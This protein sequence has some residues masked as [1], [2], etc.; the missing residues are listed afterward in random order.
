MSEITSY[1][2]VCGTLLIGASLLISFAIT[3]IPSLPSS[4]PA[5]QAVISLLR[6]VE[7]PDDAVIYELGS[8]W[9]S[10]AIELARA[11]PHAQV[12]GIEIS[13]FPYLVSRLRALRHANARFEWGNF[14]RCDL[15]DAD[16]IT[17]YLMPEK[18]ARV[19]E[20]L[21]AKLRT[22]VPVVSI[23]FWFRDRKIE[24]ARRQAKRE[25]T[26]LYIWPARMQ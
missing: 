1:V 10:L 3:G 15:S 17:C 13:P 14:D 24:A 4:K 2:L 20:L 19:A 25:A 26:A 22:N 7:V 21:D 16:A 12:R 6:E 5:A 9:G 8:G 18:M 23:E 11:F